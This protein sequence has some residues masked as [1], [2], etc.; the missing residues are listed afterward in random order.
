MTQRV[1]EIAG[2]LKGVFRPELMCD[3]LTQCVAAVQ[4]GYYASLLPVPFWTPRPETRCRIIEDPLLDL[5]DRD[6]VLAW[7]PRLIDVH[8]AA[9][10]RFKGALLGALR[11]KVTAEN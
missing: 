6:V 10:G 7:H 4:S 2:Q 9:M 1:Q 11:A 5:L 3:S 8:G